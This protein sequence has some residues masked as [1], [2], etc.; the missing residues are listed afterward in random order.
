MS[1][2]LTE[3]INGKGSKKQAKQIVALT[4]VIAKARKDY[5]NTKV[6]IEA[7]LVN[8]CE[9]MMK[10]STLTAADKLALVNR[11]IVGIRQDVAEV[12]NFLEGRVSK[13][14]L[15]NVID[16]AQAASIATNPVLANLA[17]TATSKYL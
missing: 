14:T 2:T 8:T 3:I 5:G 6:V 16:E 9:G 1:K 15:N 11:Q 17:T 13:K 12:E 10:M 4:G 7:P